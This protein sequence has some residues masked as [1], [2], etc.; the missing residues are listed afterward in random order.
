MQE[1]EASG[2]SLPTSLG[3]HWR[4]IAVAKDSETLNEK[5]VFSDGEMIFFCDAS[6]YGDEATDLAELISKAKAKR[7]SV[8]KIGG[9]RHFKGGEYVA[10]GVAVN[11]E[12]MEE[13]ILYQACYGDHAF[14][15]RLLA[16]F[17]E[18]IERDGAVFQRFCS[19]DV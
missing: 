18:T 1:I 6:L 13:H 3:D 9:Y 4:I 16:M 11:I 17:F 15:V 12:T 2:F 8:V 10:H 19:I 7:K 5:L 14:Y